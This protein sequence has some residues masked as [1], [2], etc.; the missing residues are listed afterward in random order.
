M[1]LQTLLSNAYDKFY[2]V[3]PGYRT[4]PESR[5]TILRALE[6]MIEKDQKI[7]YLTEDEVLHVLTKGVLGKFGKARDFAPEIVFAWFMDYIENERKDKAAKLFLEQQRM[8]KGNYN[9][10]DRDNDVGSIA[11]WFMNWR[12]FESKKT[13]APDAKLEE[14]KAFIAGLAQWQIEML[15]AWMKQYRPDHVLTAWLCGKLVDNPG[16]G[17]IKGR[18]VRGDGIKE[19]ADFSGKTSNFSNTEGE[20]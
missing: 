10:T 8:K 7:K 1:N 5:S 3:R 13:L 2:A 11:T 9:P 4:N 6:H 18:G 14:W 17:T 19:E 20:R 12:M 16:G 15:Y